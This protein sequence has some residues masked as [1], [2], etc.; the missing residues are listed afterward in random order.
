MDHKSSPNNS[1]RLLA[2]AGFLSAALV[3][4]VGVLYNIQV[5][6][7]DYY[8]AKSIRTIT[9]VETVEASRGVITDRSGRELVSSRSSYNLTFDSSL[10]SEEDDEN[11][12][13]LR[14]IKLCQS[15]QVG[16]TDN[17]PITSTAPFS[18]TLDK[19][20]DT[21]RSRFADFLQKDLKRVSTNLS[22]DGITEELLNSLGLDAGSLV[23]LLREKYEIPSSFSLSDARSVIG[24][25]YELSIRQL[26]STTA[27]AMVED[28]DSAMI[29]LLNDGNYAGARIT[30]S[31]VREYKTDSAAH[32]LGTVGPIWREEYLQ[33][34]DKG[35]GYNDRIGRSGV[36]LAFEAYLKGTDGKRIV[37]TNAEGKITGE[38]YEKEPQPGNTVELTIDLS[39]QK[40]VEDALAETVSAMSAKDG[41]TTRGAGAVV[42]KVGTG[43]V[44]ALA[45]YPDFDLSTYNQDYNILS[46]DLAKPLWN[47]ATMGTYA[48]GSTFKP[49]TAV[50][51]LMEGIITPYQKLKTTGH[52]TYPGDPNS[53]ANCWIYN[54]SRGNHG[55]INVSEAITVSC[56]Y[57]FAQMGY[58]LGLDKLNEYATAFGLGEHTG[59]EIG[60]AAGNLAQNKA[61]ENQAPWAAFGQASYL[62]TPIQLANYIATL[63][64]GGKHCEAHLLKAVKS[65]DN[66]Q[67]L[68]VGNTDPKNTVD[69]SGEA[70]TAVKKGMHDLTTT[71]S[72]APYFKDCV[73]DAGAKTGTAQVSKD[74]KNNGVFVCFAPYDDPEIAVSIVIEQGG[75]GS[76]LASTAVNIL[77]AYFSADEIGTAILGENQLMQ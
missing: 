15:Q 10:L 73:V 30:T 37:S 22:P 75:S 29:S 45:S 19:L 65:Y 49:L 26:V 56:N 63:V 20:D 54:S 70:L 14:L 62:F 67:V 13:I 76:A 50:A 2:L 25:Q 64:S 27:Y 57:F 69:I 44:L 38:Y 60:D 39:L 74:T 61:G 46:T 4:Y 12:A 42:I 68:A 1:K 41:N 36:E 11:L 28:I 72:L 3:I 40:S 18:Y 5:N 34:K 47:R 17:L 51:S 55:S 8:L 16:W 24:V 43:E 35:Y 33:L 66:T 32:I 23:E 6:Q 48:P 59:I 21:Q 58:Y 77:N 9:R 53:Y 52:W 31:S 71:G 7:H